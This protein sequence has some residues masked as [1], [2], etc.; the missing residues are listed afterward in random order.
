MAHISGLPLGLP[1]LNG[2]IPFRPGD[3]GPPAIARDFSGGT[4]GTLLSRGIG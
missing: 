2:A 3:A 1:C 4:G